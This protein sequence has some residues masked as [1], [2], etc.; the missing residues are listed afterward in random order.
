PALIS[1]IR[2]GFVRVSPSVEELVSDFARLRLAARRRAKPD[3]LATMFE[4]GMR[5]SFNDSKLTIRLSKRSMDLLERTAFTYAL[6]RREWKSPFPASSE[7]LAGVEPL[8]NAIVAP[9][10]A[11][12]KACTNT[13]GDKITEALCGFLLDTMHLHRTV[14]TL[15]QSGNRRKEAAL[16]PTTRSEPQA[17]EVARE[18]RQ[19][20]DALIDVFESLHVAL[21]DVSVTL[22]EYIEILRGV[23]GSVNIAKPPQVLDCVAVGDLER[24]RFEGLGIR[25]AFIM[26]AKAG[27]FP[28]SAAGIGGADSCFSGRDIEELGEHGMEITEQ[29]QGRYFFEQML[30]DKALSLPSEVLYLSAPLSDA[31]WRELSPSPVFEELKEKHKVEIHNVAELP[32]KSMQ[33]A[34][35]AMQSGEHTLT[36]ETAQKLFAFDKLKLSP[37]AVEAMMSCRF[38]YLCRFALGLRTPVAL[39]DE[40][41][42]ALERGKIIHYCLEAALREGWLLEG[43]GD[44]VLTARVRDCIRKYRSLAIPYEF[45]QTRRQEYLLMSFAAGIVRLLRNSHEVLMHSGFRQ[46]AFEKRIDADLGQGVRL[47]GVID[48]I[49]THTHGGEDYICVIDY[50]TGRTKLDLAEA[51][52]GLNLQMLLYLFALEGQGKEVGLRPTTHSEPQASRVGAKPAAAY[53]VQADGLRTEKSVLLP[54]AAGEAREKNWLKAHKPAGIVLRDNPV[55]EEFSLWEAGFRQKTNMKSGFI[56]TLTPAAYERL[57]THCISQIAERRESIALGNVSA[58]PVV[59]DKISERKACDYC[60]FGAVCGKS[61]EEVIDRMRVK[62][63]FDS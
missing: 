47:N 24:S 5:Y 18:F 59:S 44:A 38:M 30:V 55:Y 22:S 54:N 33:Y 29:L 46:S 49:D 58:V 37:T 21:K 13:T 63:V 61:S 40:E 25:A 12:R 48:R 51:C 52:Y 26:G 43:G 45:A 23:C 34:P 20:W 15:C 11:L 41:P 62:E 1:Y 35:V 16:C 57:K 36:P 3:F 9:L 27:A 10:I 4:S 53:Y 17:S 2:S 19:L 32:V 6:K 39:N 56:S 42:I 7:E 31:A 28:R 14:F 60:E 50:K 8:R